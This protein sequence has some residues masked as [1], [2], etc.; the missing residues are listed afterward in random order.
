MTERRAERRTLGVLLSLGTGDRFGADF[1]R[2]LARFKDR[3]IEADYQRH[4]IAE[5]L[6]RE[7]LISYCLVAVYFFY[8]ILDIL[9]IGPERLPMVLTVRWAVLTPIALALVLLTHVERFK[10]YY[11]QIFTFGVFLFAASIVWMISILPADG[12]PPYIIGVLMVFIFASC[13]I[14]M[15]FAAATA[16]FL[17]TA[18]AYTATLLLHPKFSRIDAIAGPFFM[19]SA[20]IVAVV[21][22]YTQEVRSRVIWRQ[23]RQRARDADHIEQLMIEATAAD[24]SKINF[25]S[26]LSHELRTPLHQIIGF[27]EVLR[28]QAADSAGSDTAEFLDQIHGSAHALLARIGKML[29]YADATAGKI[30]YAPESYAAREIVE[31]VCGQFASRAAAR[32]VRL[33]CAGVDPGSV[34]VDQS[35]VVYALG[36]LVENAIKASSG[37]QTVKVSGAAGETGYRIEI[38]DD[39]QGMTADQIRLAFEPFSQTETP[40]TRSS[41]GVGLGL[42]LAKKIFADQGATLT[43]RST[44]GVGTTVCVDF[45]R[46]SRMAA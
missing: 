40:K 14:S 28:K 11:P 46:R 12:A 43:I 17:A 38:R 25:L 37:G 44:P 10:P 16:V 21:S 29:R 30:N 27:S 8:G 5:Q 31:V 7:R 19:F 23:T 4:L 2:L 41:E 45:A 1:D 6:G 22:N 18:F 33:D 24:Q 34:F 39:G 36:H 9:T 15:P 32:H 20:V 35:S 42:T 13:S 26:I 3:Q